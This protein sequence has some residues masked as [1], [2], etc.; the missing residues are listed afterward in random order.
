MHQDPHPAL[1]L[2]RLQHTSHTV[3]PGLRSPSPLRQH[4]LP[5]LPGRSPPHSYQ[6]PRQ[7]AANP[8]SR[9]AT[10]PPWPNPGN[11]RHRHWVPDAPPARDLPVHHQ[12]A[13]VT[14]KAPCVW[15]TQH[16]L[17]AEPL[18]KCSTQD[19]WH[20]IPCRNS[21]SHM[22][23]CPLARHSNPHSY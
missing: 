9:M 19:P 5:S 22:G 10:S 3:N 21:R 4:S 6:Q 17:P 13:R 7:H 20:N 2:Q 18:Q 8:A 12:G 14:I 23:S 15:L 11:V 16:A 1:Q